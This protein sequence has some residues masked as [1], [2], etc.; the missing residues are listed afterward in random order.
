MLDVR[1]PRFDDRDRLLRWRNEERVRQVSVNDGIIGV[2]SHA[3]WFEHVI[4]GD[5]GLFLIVEV[6]EVPMGVVRVDHEP[7][8]VEVMSWSCHA[9]V[10]GLTPGAGAS[11]PVIALGLGF[12]QHGARRM[13]ADVLSNNKNMRGVHRRLGLKQEG[14]RRQQVK[15]ATGAVLDVH[16]FGVLAKEW[17]EIYGRALS[18]LPSAIRSDLSHILESLGAT[19]RGDVPN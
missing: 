8:T 19:G 11:L 17:P 1:G 7:A 13:V 10:D 5:S 9:G 16:E 6:N 14:V 2:E 12:G 15:R 18:L 4:D 3:R